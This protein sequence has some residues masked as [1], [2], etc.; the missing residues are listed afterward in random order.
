MAKRAMSVEKLAKVSAADLAAEEIRRLILAGELAPGRRLS[1]ERDLAEHLGVSRAAMRN[2]L[3]RLEREGL[4]TAKVGHGRVVNSLPPAASATRPAEPPAEVIAILIDEDAT[5]QQL[6]GM[7]SSGWSVALSAGAV[8][9][10]FA[11]GLPTLLAPAGQADPERRRRCF[12]VQPA[13]LAVVAEP[14]DL[15]SREDLLRT[16]RLG[17]IPVAVYGDM[18]AWPGCDVVCSDHRQGSR[19][20]VDW[21]V[22]RG[23]RAILRIVDRRPAESAWARERRLGFED[24]C[25]RAGSPILPP[26]DIPPLPSYDFSRAAF[27]A[28]A[29]QLAGY[30]FRRLDQK[31][32]I[33]A[34][35]ADSDGMVLK[36]AAALRILGRDPR[37]I[38]IVG[39]DNYWQALPERQWEDVV[40][41]A[42]VDKDN[43]RIGQEIIR[44]L[45]R[46]LAGQL[47][48]GPERISVPQRLL[49]VESPR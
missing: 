39:Y 8:S 29:H 22:A 36:V 3:Q 25:R 30:L 44:L 7:G 2:G 12:P 17:D 11:Q 34:V 26:L 16:F 49:V 42:T 31:P 40:P 48:H 32:R 10:A 38:P 19:D 35:M 14:P 5:K 28:A 15:H 23:S 6:L 1:S 9:E 45:H 33:D 20:A 4:V 24:A 13:G 18:H 43:F 27:D 37:A 46:R 21:L 41:S 47:G